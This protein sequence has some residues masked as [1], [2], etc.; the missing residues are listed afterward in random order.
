[1]ML[2][3]SGLGL[4]TGKFR[5][6]LTELSAQDTI[7]A[8]YYSLTFLLIP[9]YACAKTKKKSNFLNVNASNISCMSGKPTHVNMLV[10]KQI[11]FSKYSCI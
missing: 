7:M 10:L 3:R 4:P 11:D 2:W 6:I 1:M 9:C 5:Q 8:G